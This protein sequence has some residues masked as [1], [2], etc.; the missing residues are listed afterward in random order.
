MVYQCSWKM[1]LFI[2]GK[3]WFAHDEAL[4]TPEP[5]FLWTVDRTGRPSQL[6]FTI[7]WPQSSG[8][9]AVWTSKSLWVW[10]ADLWLAGITATNREW[11]L[12]DR[13]KPESFEAVS[14]SV[15]RRAGSRVDMH[16]TQCIFYWYDIIIINTW[17]VIG[18]G[19]C[20]PDV[21]LLISVRTARLSS[22]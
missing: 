12:R 11:L 6:A 17:V 21:L 14:T 13:V 10:R 18:V 7:S 9:L 1:C 20:G 15:I 8:L 19:V 2:D 16:R 3:T 5:H 22:Q 4:P